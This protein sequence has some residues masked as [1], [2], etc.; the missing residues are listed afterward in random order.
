MLLKDELRVLLEQDPILYSD[1]QGLIEQMLDEIGSVDAELRDQ[2]IYTMFGRLISEGYVTEQQ[3]IYI[4]DRCREKLVEGI[5]EVESDTVFTRS[6][7]ALTITLILQKDRQTPFLSTEILFH[8]FK[9]GMNYLKL[10]QD[11]RGHVPGKGWAHS[12]AHGADLLTEIV[13]HPEF[14]SRLF[15][16]VLDTIN[17][18]LFK[19]RTGP[20]IDDEEER[21]LFA[22]DALIEKGISTSELTAFIQQLSTSLHDVQRQNGYELDFYWKRSN[23]IHFL[24]GF[25]FRLVYKNTH[26]DLRDEILAILQNWHTQMYGTE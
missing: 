23:M 9:E 18:C 20:Y 19:N 12:I 8:V 14:P 24:R 1:L 21:L 2:L 26:P 5:G 10:E 25:Y 22:I 3:A 16:N 11:V 4:L 15:V 13:R 17:I 6:F 7:S